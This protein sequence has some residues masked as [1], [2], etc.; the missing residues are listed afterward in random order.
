MVLGSILYVKRLITQIRQYPTIDKMEI[1]MRVL[2][3]GEEDEL[4]QTRKQIT[5]VITTTVTYR[6]NKAKPVQDDCAT[7]TKP[8]G[9]RESE[10][11]HNGVAGNHFLH[12]FVK[13]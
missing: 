6:R 2:K 13:T 4:R 7:E 5:R 10:L 12:T 8:A 11:L 9:S 1:E 3:P